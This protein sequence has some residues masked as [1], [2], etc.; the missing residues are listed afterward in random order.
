[1]ST[2]AGIGTNPA[3]HCDRGDLRSELIYQYAFP[4]FLSNQLNII[5]VYAAPTAATYT[6]KP[7]G[8]GSIHHYSPD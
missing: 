8:V 2:K 5:A 6:S 3:H 7:G 1:M 4:V